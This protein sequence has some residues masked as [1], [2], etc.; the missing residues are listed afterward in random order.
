MARVKTSHAVIIC[1][2]AD[3]Q[4][5]RAAPQPRPRV[6]ITRWHHVIPIENGEPWSGP[7]VVGGVL[8]RCTDDW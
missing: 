7:T 6:Y 1:R 2:Y 3:M 4:T 5:A 8:S